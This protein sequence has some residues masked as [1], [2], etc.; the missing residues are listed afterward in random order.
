MNAKS[1][2]PMQGIAAAMAHQVHALT[3]SHAS[4]ECNAGFCAQPAPHGVAYAKTI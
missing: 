1:F 3:L 4:G 2:T